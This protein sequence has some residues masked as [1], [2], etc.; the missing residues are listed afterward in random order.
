MLYIRKSSRKWGQRGHK[1]S[2]R[3]WFIIWTITHGKITL[4]V[5]L[6]SFRS[7]YGLISNVK[8]SLYVCL[9][10][11]ITY[12]F[13]I[14]LLLMFS[15]KT[16]V[17]AF[18]AYGICLFP[19][20][21]FA[22]YVFALRSQEICLFPFTRFVISIYISSMRVSSMYLSCKCEIGIYMFAI[23]MFTNFVVFSPLKFYCLCHLHVCCIFSI[24][25]CHVCPLRMCLFTLRTCLPSM[26]L[27]ISW[28]M[29][30]IIT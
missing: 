4:R 22:I 16:Y 13:F 10:I 12:I 1:F 23:S 18:Y 5:N 24:R 20:I 14:F 15:F 19:S 11:Y 3:K 2:Q 17:F 25:L 30:L 29:Y 21:H 27:L 6:S 8:C 26:S 9:I 28:L 7:M